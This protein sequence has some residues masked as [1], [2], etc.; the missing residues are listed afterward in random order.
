MAQFI[1][2]ND[3]VE[4]NQQ[5]VL[6]VVNSLDNG[7]DVRRNILESNNID[8][9]NKEW[10]IQQDWLNAFKEI[11][12]SLGGMNLFMIGKD[13]INSAQFPP[14]KDLEQALHSLDGAYHMNHRLNGKIMFDPAKGTMTEGIGHYS[15][16][17]FDS[18][19]RKATMVCNNP[20]PSKFDEGIITQ[21][22]RRFKPSGSREAVMLNESLETRLHGGDS[23]TYF[24]NW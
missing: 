12:N 14:M 9:D 21:V 18:K 7:K 4:V 16:Q 6:S 15:V 23:C 10:F 3:Q 13:I 19:A 20:Y 1:A 22:V 24:I 5:V 8:L 11:S 17:E 2:F